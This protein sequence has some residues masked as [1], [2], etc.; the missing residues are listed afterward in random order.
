MTKLKTLGQHVVGK[1]LGHSMAIKVGEYPTIQALRNAYRARGIVL[2]ESARQ[3]FCKV[4]VHLET[5]SVATAMFLS[6]DD[7]RYPSG[8][9]LKN[10]YGR[11]SMYKLA[12]STHETALLFALQWG[13]AL[14]SS[15]IVLATA[16]IPCVGGPHLF[17]VF[18]LNGVRYV[19]G[20]VGSVNQFFDA[21]TRFMFTQILRWK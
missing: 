11:A 6:N 20:E 19:S 17:R 13:G 8:T 16:P 2:N 14:S 7:L 18:D 9:Q 1:R 4:S 21:H 12:P 5:E 10:S 3:M 15:G